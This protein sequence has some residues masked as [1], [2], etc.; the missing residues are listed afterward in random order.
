[1]IRKSILVSWKGIL[2]DYRIKQ[3]NYNNCCSRNS[4]IF[5]GNSMR[6]LVKLIKSFCRILK[7][8]RMPLFSRGMR[9]RKNEINGKGNK[10]N[11]RLW[12][13]ISKIKFNSSQRSWNSR[14]WNINQKYK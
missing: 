13:M 4:R 2:R 12:L 6:R 11:L 5:K 10:I 8:L 3:A 9:I 14:E 1:M 7:N